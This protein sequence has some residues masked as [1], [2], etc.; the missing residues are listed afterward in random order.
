MDYDTKVLDWV[1]VV[2]DANRNAFEKAVNEVRK[3][4]SRTSATKKGAS[5]LVQSF[6]DSL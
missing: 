1:R 4:L 5:N 2:Q 6:K 3:G